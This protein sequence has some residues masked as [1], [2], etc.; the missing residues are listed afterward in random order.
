[1]TTPSAEG[2][3][4][5]TWRGRALRCERV[6]GLLTDAGVGRSALVVVPLRAALCGGTGAHD[7]FLMHLAATVDLA[8]RGLLRYPVNLASPGP[9]R[10]IRV[11]W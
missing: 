2:T 4:T 11:H 9:G 1:M 5:A 7:A 10:A 3:C 6:S 8:R